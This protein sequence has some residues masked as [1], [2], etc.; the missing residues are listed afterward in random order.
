MT[1]NMQIRNVVSVGM[2]ANKPKPK[3]PTASANRM[4][5]LRFA[6]RSEKCPITNPPTMAT[7]A[8]AINN[9]AYWLSDIPS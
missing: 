9:K 1:S 2:T 7:A 8:M 3:L 5:L 6:A 4:P